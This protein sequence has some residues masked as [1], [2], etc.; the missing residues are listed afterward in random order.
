MKNQ[1][2]YQLTLF[3]ALGALRAKRFSAQEY[4]AELQQRIAE[5]DGDIEAWA[6]YD[7]CQGLSAARRSDM[8]ALNAAPRAR[9]HTRVAAD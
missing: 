8:R 1:I 6:H 3:E 7:P 5:R 4:C 9:S 2:L